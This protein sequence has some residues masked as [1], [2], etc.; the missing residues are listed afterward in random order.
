MRL[1][2]LPPSTRAGC[3]ATEGA[4]GRFCE[5]VVGPGGVRVCVLVCVSGF[6]WGSRSARG[7]VGSVASWRRGCDFSFFLKERRAQVSLLFY[8]SKLFGAPKRMKRCPFAR[9]RRSASASSLCFCCGGGR[10]SWLAAGRAWPRSQSACTRP[11][12]TP[13]YDATRTC[14][15][16]WGWSARSSQQRLHSKRQP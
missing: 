9:V 4:W 7:C 13:C 2:C 16:R 14:D 10:S 5:P 15:S 1:A 12:R 11:V 3:R 8:L 6:V